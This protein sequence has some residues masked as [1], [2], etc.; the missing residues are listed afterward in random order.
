[1]K[2][3]EIKLD[4]PPQMVTVLPAWNKRTRNNQGTVAVFTQLQ[5]AFNRSETINT[6]HMFW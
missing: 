1:M 4:Q 6:E 3:P 2:K 5:R